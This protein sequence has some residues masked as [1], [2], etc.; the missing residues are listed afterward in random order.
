MSGYSQDLFD[1]QASQDLFDSQEFSTQDDLHNRCMEIS[2]EDLPNTY[3]SGESESST[4]YGT[5]NLSDHSVDME[6][7]PREVTQN[8]DGMD[9][10][11]NVSSDTTDMDIDETTSNYCCHSMNHFEEELKRMEKAFIQGSDT[12]CHGDF[13]LFLANAVEY[14]M[15]EKIFSYAVSEQTLKDE[16]DSL[17]IRGIP[18]LAN[19]PQY[20]EKKLIEKYGAEF[21]HVNYVSHNYRKLHRLSCNPTCMFCTK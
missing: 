19:L 10:D 3:I 21:R 17:R 4:D 20:F 5:N 13:V 6:L 18:D 14:Y 15:N 9:I 8:N 16:L 1:S 7:L 2:S 12:L 11:T